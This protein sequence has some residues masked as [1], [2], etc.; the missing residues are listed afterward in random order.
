MYLWPQQDMTR[1]W[2]VWSVYMVFF[3]ASNRRR[4]TSCWYWAVAC[5][6]W[7]VWVLWNICLAGFVS[8]YPLC[9]KVFHRIGCSESRECGVVAITDH[10]EQCGFGGKPKH[11]M[12]VSNHVCSWW[13]VVDVVNTFQCGMAQDAGRFCEWS[14]PKAVFV[15]EPLRMAGCLIVM[16]M[17]LWSWPVA[18]LLPSWKMVMY[19]LL[20]KVPMMRR[21]LEDSA[22]R[23]WVW[24][25]RVHTVSLVGVQMRTCWQLG[26]TLQW[27]VI[28]MR[29]VIFTSCEMWQ[30]SSHH[31]CL[32]M[33]LWRHVSGSCVGGEIIRLS[34]EGQGGD[35]Q[36]EVCR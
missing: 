26:W 20:A 2:P 13:E 18:P 31:L 22:C 9:S 16:V 34:G 5:S 24:C 32:W 15:L 23:T 25:P 7:G 35:A 12:E 17:S 27:E 4:N 3:V 19:P 29:R 21:E 11:G 30:C 33:C 36:V 6:L 14:V 1:K 8:C 10:G 28:E